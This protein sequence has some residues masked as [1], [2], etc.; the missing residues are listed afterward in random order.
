MTSPE[1]SKSPSLPRPL[2][3]I[4]PPIMTPLRDPDALD[5]EGTARLIDHVIDGGVA[6]LFVLGT[7]GEA[8]HLSNALKRDMLQ[9]TVRLTAGRVPVLVGVTEPSLSGT[10][11]MAR[12]AADAG[13][14][15]VVVSAPFYLPVTQGEL[16]TFV[17]AV[18]AGQP[19]PVFC[20]NIPQLTKVAYAPETLRRLLDEPRVVGFKDSAGDWEYF[21]QAMDIA[22]ERPAFSVLVG[23]ESLLA[24]AMRRGAHG[25]VCGGANLDPSFFVRLAADAAAGRAD[26]RAEQRLVALHRLY[27][28]R[29]IS[30][31]LKLIKYCLSLRN[32]C[33]PTMAAPL[34]GLTEEQRVEADLRFDELMAGTG[35][36]TR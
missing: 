27:V 23:S 24:R 7:T 1:P 28:R 6:G 34:A 20:Y 30:H 9:E 19:L 11:D 13:A 8:S 4:I 2:R 35:H 29:D 25:G 5:V 22:A 12:A 17:K 14:D 16:L 31:S 33:A 3:G 18:A 10:L 36:R 15:A 26:E 32:L 21:E